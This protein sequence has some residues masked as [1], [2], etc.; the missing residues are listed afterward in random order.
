MA[1]SALAFSILALDHG[2]LASLTMIKGNKKNTL[3][4]NRK[5][6]FGINSE[7]TSSAQRAVQSRNSRGRFIPTT[8]STLCRTKK[9]LAQII[10]VQNQIWN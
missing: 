7:T 4:M 2:F 3:V 6:N 1:E 8:I 5:A 10:A 9:I